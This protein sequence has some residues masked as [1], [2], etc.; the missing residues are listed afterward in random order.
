MKKLSTAKYLKKLTNKLQLFWR[1][2]K[3]QDFGLC[4]MSLTRYLK[5]RKDAEEKDMP[6]ESLTV[7]YQKN[8]QVFNDEQEP[9]VVS[10]AI[11]CSQYCYGLTL[12]DVKQL[13][14]SCALKHNIVIPQLRIDKKDAGS[15]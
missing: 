9:V 5:K 1:R 8:K 3:S 12:K 14:L 2:K 15:G 13:A 4:H 11:K 6:M 10:Y 7:G